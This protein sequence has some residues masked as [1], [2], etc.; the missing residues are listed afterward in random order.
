VISL[1]R[2][3]R[4]IG[5]VRTDLCLYNGLPL[6]EF[7]G[8]PRVELLSVIAARSLWLAVNL[9]LCATIDT[10]ALPLTL[11]LALARLAEG[12][13]TGSIIVDGPAD[14]L[15]ESEWRRFWLGNEP[16]VT[17]GKPSPK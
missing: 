9:P 12:A 2:I 1:S 16:G 17:L 3:A 15:L 4:R 5:G 11:P 14:K 8:K 6:E 13:S 10:V 7:D